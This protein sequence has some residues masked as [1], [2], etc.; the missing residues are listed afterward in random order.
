MLEFLPDWWEVGTVLTGVFGLIL[1]LFVSIEFGQMVV[2]S[3]KYPASSA[4]KKEV[5]EHART[6][7]LIVLLM[8]S[9]PFIWPLYAIIGIGSIVYAV[10]ALFKNLIVYAWKV[11]TEE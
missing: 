11:V 8:L 2:F 4:A 3:R 6:F 7:W 1:L 5:Q 9:I 10:L